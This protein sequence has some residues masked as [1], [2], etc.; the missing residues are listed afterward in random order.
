LEVSLLVYWQHLLYWESSPILL[1]RGP[2]RTVVSV[3]FTLNFEKFLWLTGDTGI[4]AIFEPVRARNHRRSSSFCSPESNVDDS[5][6]SSRISSKASSIHNGCAGVGT[7]VG[8]YVGPP[9]P[10][11]PN[12]LSSF[13]TNRPNQPSLRFFEPEAHLLP[14][15][16]SVRP[17]SRRIH[18]RFVSQPLLSRPPTTDPPVE[19][20]SPLPTTMSPGNLVVR[21]NTDSVP[22]SPTDLDPFRPPSLLPPSRRSESRTSDIYEDLKGDSSLAYLS[23]AITSD[24]YS[25]RASP[26]HRS[27]F[28]SPPTRCATHLSVSSDA[29]LYSQG[30]SP[31][32]RDS[33]PADPGSDRNRR[34]LWRHN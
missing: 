13:V 31:P 27:R 30:D 17:S 32:V 25:T 23:Q 9:L 20:F 8:P 7:R 16:S 22:Y 6:D 28:L 1:G 33:S 14:T 18:R 21:N 29:S 2:T 15:T 3:Y 34:C 26:S 11:V 12:P 24:D 5:R 10:P 4:Q 19:T